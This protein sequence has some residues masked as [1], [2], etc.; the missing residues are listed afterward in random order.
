MRVALILYLT[1]AV[2]LASLELP[3]N[4]HEMADSERELY[5]VPERARALGGDATEADGTFA[6]AE[7][8]RKGELRPSQPPPRHARNWMRAFLQTEKG[9]H[10]SADS[11]AHQYLLAKPRWAKGDDGRKSLV[12]PLLTWTADELC[13]ALAPVLIDHLVAFCRR[14]QCGAERQEPFAAQSLPQPFNWLDRLTM[15]RPHRS[16]A[17]PPPPR[18][19]LRAR[20][21]ADRPAAPLADDT[22]QA[23]GPARR[24]V[25]RAR[26]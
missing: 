13:R 5:L 1:H 20:L 24:V 26:R 23:Q 10:R 3:D 6:L 17:S 7:L 2:A 15:V 9:Q 22:E 14:Q 19:P 11:P 18:H 25:A 16:R 8:E 21:A 4:W 12:P